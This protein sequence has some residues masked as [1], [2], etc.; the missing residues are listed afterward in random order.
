MEIIKIS[1]NIYEIPRREKMN[2]PVRIYASDKLLEKMKEDKTLIQATNVAKLPGIKKW[3]IVLPDGHEG[4]GFPVG[5]VA[6]FDL[7]EGI[8][9]PGGI[10]YDINCGVRILRTNLDQK[11]IK[12][13]LKQIV[14]EIFKNVPAGVGEVGHLKLSIGQFK[15]AVEEGLEWTYREGYAWK[16]DIESVESYGKLENASL[17]AVSDF[18]IR[19]GLDQFGTLGSGNHFLE[20]QVVD[21]IFDLELA[22]YLGIEEEGQVTVMIHTGSRGF[23]HQIATDY[24]DLFMKKY[25]EIVK[26]LPDRELIYAPFNSEEGQRYWKAM[27]A[28]ANFAWV[29]RQII[30][31]WIRKSFEKIFRASAEDLGLFTIYDV[32]HN[33]AKIE[34]HIINGK[35]EKVIVH[36]KGATRA[37]PQNHED[38]PE[39]YRRIGQPVLIPGSMGTA[40]YILVAGINSMELSFGSSA[41]GAGRT[42]SRAAAK[43][44]YTYTEIIRRFERE[45]II[46]KST[47]KEGVV[48]EVPEAYKNVDEVVRV[49]HDL[50]ISKIVVKLR[51]IAVIKG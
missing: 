32:A 3:A 46:I 50:G 49:T 22:K 10:G 11:E 43:R 25:R 2:V 12:D 34:T 15:E 38:L 28:A 5:G 31:Y 30:T 7:K 18:A 44:T 17:D 24:I 29:N 37:F 4:Y 9:S 20:I 42:M 19:R 47:T 36:R 27:A 35:K 51:P 13:K 45:G 21:K 23:G 1:E 41:H 6:A 16:E 39:K 40:S 26:T 48:E 33:I 8:I 14:E